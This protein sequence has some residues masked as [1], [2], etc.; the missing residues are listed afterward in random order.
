MAKNYTSRAPGKV[1]VRL[2]LDRAL[3]DRLRIR[4]AEARLPMSQLAR[5]YVEDALEK[6]EKKS[7]KGG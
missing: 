7:R 2:D 4:A 5:S 1:S 3:H 6:T